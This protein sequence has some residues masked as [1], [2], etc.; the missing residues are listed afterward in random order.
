MLK[1]KKRIWPYYRK[2][3]S[4]IL[5]N[6]DLV[7]IDNNT[8]AVILETVQ[9]G[10]GFIIPKNGYLNNVKKSVRSWSTFDFR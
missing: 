3:I 1:T 10:A 4:L 8:A 2:L 9:G 6:K 7:K 5:S